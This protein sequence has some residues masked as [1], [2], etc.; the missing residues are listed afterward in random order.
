MR[1]ESS[2]GLSPRSRGG[3]IWPSKEAIMSTRNQQ[4]SVIPGPSDGEAGTASAP[5]ARRDVALAMAVVTLL[6]MGVAVGGTLAPQAEPAIAT[7]SGAAAAQPSQEFVYYPS[8]YVNQGL[9][10]PEPIPTF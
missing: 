5:S 3:T 8:Q 7:Q 4:L 10:I 6:L 1:S 2:T 9:E